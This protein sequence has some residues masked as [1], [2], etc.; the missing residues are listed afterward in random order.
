[1]IYRLRS[2]G[3]FGAAMAATALILFGSLATKATADG[4]HHM[5]HMHAYGRDWIL[6]DFGVGWGWDSVYGYYQG[7]I[8]RGNTGYFR[9]F[10]PGYGWH[11]CPNYWIVPGRPHWW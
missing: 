7:P 2:L 5:R 10:E 11:P 6:R 4:N 1:M 9:C 3:H 8:F